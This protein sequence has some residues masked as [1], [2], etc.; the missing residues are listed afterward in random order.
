MTEDNGCALQPGLK[1]RTLGSDSYR[2][3]IWGFEDILRGTLIFKYSNVQM[4]KSNFTPVFR[5]FVP[6]LGVSSQKFEQVIIRCYY[7][8][9]MALLNLDKIVL[10]RTVLGPSCPHCACAL[11]ACELPDKPAWW[12]RLLHG[13]NMIQYKCKGCGRQYELFKK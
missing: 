4:C 10:H 3:K 13:K 1:L 12:K 6:S 5:R 7:C 8:V 2:E 9:Q 11:E